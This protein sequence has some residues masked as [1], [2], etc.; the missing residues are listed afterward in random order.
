[1]DKKGD[2]GLSLDDIQA[3]IQRLSKTQPDGF[4]TQQMAEKT[5]RGPEWCR[6]KIKQLMQQNVLI[7]N[8][9]TTITAIDGRSTKVPVYKLLDNRAPKRK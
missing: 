3:E 1:M 5:G 7:F 4:T 9:K 6:V 8:G 2:M